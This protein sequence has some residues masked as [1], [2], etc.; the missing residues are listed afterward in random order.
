MQVS[1]ILH[2]DGA[3]GSEAPIIMVLGGKFRISWG[4]FMDNHDKLRLATIGADKETVRKIRDNVALSRVAIVVDEIM[5][6]EKLNDFLVRT[7]PNIVVVG[8][9]NDISE[10]DGRVVIRGLKAVRSQA[11]VL[12]VVK[13][14][15][16]DQVPAMYDAGI[17]N[18]ILESDV[19]TELSRAATIIG[20]AG[21]YISRRIFTLIREP[22]IRSFYAALNGA[23]LLSPGETTGGQLSL[24]EELVLKLFAFGFS[25][26]EIAAELKIS[27][28]TVETYKSRA[29]AK[30]S[31]TSRV[32]IVKYGC[33][34][35]WFSV[36]IN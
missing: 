21:N 7:L 15:L 1:K 9:R 22:N 31:L 12:Y 3:K 17:H 20:G 2:D 18:I 5:E 26:K 19:A 16:I 27:T 36:L 8:I 13:D 32:A 33:N 4:T 14:D 34:R 30:L 28:K 24:R 35:G 11:A 25:T 10:F 23:P 6:F 29:S